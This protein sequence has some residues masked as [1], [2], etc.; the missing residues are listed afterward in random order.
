MRRRLF[1]VLIAG[2]VLTLSS[3]LAATNCGNEAGSVR[4]LSNDFDSL[5]VVG[6]AA[7]ECASA[8]VAV[9]RNQ[10]TDHAKLQV[11]AL[12]ANP[13]RYTV[14]LVSNDSMTALLNDALLRPLDDLVAKYGQALKKNQLVTID[15][16]VMAVAFM[17]NAQL[18][19]YR[20]DV[21]E[22]VGLGAP[23]S[24]EEVLEAARVIRDKGVMQYP[25]AATDRPDWDLAE[26]FVNMYLGYG[27]ELFDGSS[28]RAA[29]ANDEGIKALTMMKALT[30]YMRADFLTY[31][32]DIIA[33][34]WEANEVAMANL[35]GSRADAFVN[36][37]SRSTPAARAT[38]F[39]P[40]PTVGGGTTPAT[41]LWWD[42]FAIAKNIDD[43]DAVAS[44]KTMLHAISPA[45]AHAHPDAAV[46]L[47]SDS[48]TSAAAKGILETV[49]RGA[50]SYPMAPYM[51]Y[52]HEALGANL[53]AFMQ[54]RKSAQE[55]LQ[56]IVKTYSTAAREA[57]YLR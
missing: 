28:A 18:L 2:P 53:A 40:A 49:R 41:T 20:E 23:R 50:K 7:M 31:S 57:G 16:K 39:V 13:A 10:T 47:A 55:T 42:A 12:K 32:T 15:G 45:V 14:V 9:S 38:R 46:W 36:G 6:A 27:G 22:E 29:I 43:N 17:V 21:L 48:N 1:L 54:G 30:G 11:P 37:R 34:M 19:Y 4:I 33:P 52:L 35:W 3:V 26:E 51:G 44:F 8:A 24:Y 5:R 25:L 56:D